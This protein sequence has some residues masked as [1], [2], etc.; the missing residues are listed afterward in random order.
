V[1]Q[2]RPESFAL[3]PLLAG[4][5]ASLMPLALAK[6]LRL[7]LHAPDAAW[8]HADPMLLRRIVANL[9]GNALRYTPRGSVLLAA[10]RRGG[11]WQ[12]ECRDSG[13]GIARESQKRVFDEFVQLHNPERDRRHGLGLG[14]AIAQRSAQLMGSRIRLRSAPG[15]GSVFALALPQAVPRALSFGPGQG[16]PSFDAVEGAEEADPLRGKWILVIDDEAAIREGLELL[17]TQWGCRVR[18]VSDHAGALAEATRGRPDLVLA[19]LR[20]PG[21]YSGL[22]TLAD[23][24][25]IHGV[26][27]PVCLITGEA[28]PAALR[29]ARDSGVPLL[30]K[31]VRPAK[32]RATLLHLL[33][34]AE[35]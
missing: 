28:D 29:A 34:R 9:L 31:P 33:Q 16:H 23:L 32:L 2:A 25:S 21:E 27:L 8:V 24:R 10:R 11:Q 6:G 22:E 4:E 12:V 13:I 35:T 7:R 17:L 1:V 30:H 19:D 26:D 18:S 5:V 15:R 3:A 20:L 14:L